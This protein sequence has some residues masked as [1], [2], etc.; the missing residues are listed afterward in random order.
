MVSNATVCYQC[1]TMDLDECIRGN[2]ASLDGIYSSSK[3]SAFHLK[4][5]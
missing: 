5:D 4:L 3:V 2:L 1:K